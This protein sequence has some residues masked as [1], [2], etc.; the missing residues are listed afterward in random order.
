MKLTYRNFV[1]MPGRMVKTWLTCLAVSRQTNGHQIFR[2][3]IALL[4]HGVERQKSAILILKLYFWDSRKIKVCNQVSRVRVGLGL[5]LVL[6]IRP[7]DST[8]QI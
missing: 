2:S 8:V 4:C 3:N 6:F 5:V 7:K 1:T